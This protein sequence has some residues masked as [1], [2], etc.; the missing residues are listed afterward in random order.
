M[1]MAGHA[2]NP[3]RL[4]H[5]DSLPAAAERAKAWRQPCAG[6][7][8]HACAYLGDRVGEAQA[9][10]GLR[11]AQDGQQ[12]ARGRV[13]VRHLRGRLLRAHLRVHRRHVLCAQ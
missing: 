9:R 7:S 2:V 13:A 1:L 10:E 12:R 5:S 3:A 4:V 8:M 11:K 6:D